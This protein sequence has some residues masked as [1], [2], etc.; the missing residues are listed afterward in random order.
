MC[1][2]LTNRPAVGR[3]LPGGTRSRESISSRALRGI[4]AI[5]NVCILMDI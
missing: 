1:T 3:L 5:L 2:R 4:C